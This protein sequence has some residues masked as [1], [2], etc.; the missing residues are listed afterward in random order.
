M[1][2]KKMQMYQMCV[3]SVY[4][5]KCDDPDAGMVEKIYE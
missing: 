3:L 1:E 2:A 5:N 4:T